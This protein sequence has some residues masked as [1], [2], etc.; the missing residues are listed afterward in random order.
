MKPEQSSSPAVL[1]VG[2]NCIEQGCSFLW[3][4]GRDSYVTRAGTA[5]L[6]SSGTTSRTSSST[7]PKRRRTAA[8]NRRVNLFQAR[9]VHNQN[10]ASK[11]GAF[12]L[13]V[14]CNWCRT[15]NAMQMAYCRAYC[16]L[17]L[18]RN[19]LRHISMQFRSEAVLPVHHMPNQWGLCFDFAR[20]VPPVSFEPRLRREFI[21]SP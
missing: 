1:S 5:L 13:P 11:T 4:S 6:W 7:T 9:H 20:L 3:I 19:L 2:K 8:L 21:L 12:S 16:H 18:W 10:E 14:F 15:R 17:S